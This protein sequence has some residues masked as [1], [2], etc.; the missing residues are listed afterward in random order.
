MSILSIAHD[1]ETK[2]KNMVEEQD[3]D[4]EFIMVDDEEMK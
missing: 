3:E 4:A 1:A 2:T